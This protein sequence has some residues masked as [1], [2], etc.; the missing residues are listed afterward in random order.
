MA[1]PLLTSALDLA[2]HTA[3]G[4]WQKNIKSGIISQLTPDDPQIMVGS[5]DFFTFTGTPKAELVGE[6]ANKS[7]ADGT[8]SKKTSK[9][10]K[11]QLTYRFSDEVRY[12]DEEYR[13]GLME[14]LAGNI[15][16]GVSRAVD[17]VAI[18]G[19]NPSTGE[20]AESVADYI[21][22][23]GNGHVINSTSATPEVDLD[24]AAAALQGSGYAATG[25]AL[26]PVYAGVLARTKK[27]N[28]DR[29]FPELGLGF[30][31]ERIAGIDA[32]VSNTVSGSAEFPGAIST[33]VGGIMADW[34]A[35]KWGIARNVPLH[36]IEYGDPDGA[37]D[38]QR[39][40]EIAIRA[41]VVFGFA[42][43]D[44]KAFSII[45]QAQVSA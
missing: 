18:H 42:I 45:K 34:N 17:L 32:A 37:G 5:T 9:T 36:L 29:V 25:I 23:S 31:V 22:K 16:K 43:L 4:I 41:E 10:Y 6:G 7:S 20:V 24:A 38:L 33:G 15:A 30:N 2:K 12:A 27:T 8:P 44:D 3:S 35:I 40:N 28:G 11:V 14:A 1:N 26:D 39:T 13:L 19:I 21:T